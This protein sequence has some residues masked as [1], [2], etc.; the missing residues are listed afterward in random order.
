MHWGSRLAPAE[1]RLR[2]NLSSFPSKD[3]LAATINQSVFTALDLPS[4]LQ[5][6]PASVCGISMAHCQPPLPG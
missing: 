4:G 2:K 3:V 6:H 5:H 1:G